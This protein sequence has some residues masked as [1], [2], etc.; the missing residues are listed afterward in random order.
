MSV[1]FSMDSQHFPHGLIPNYHF[2]MRISMQWWAGGLRA[3]WKAARDEHNKLT[4]G[5]KVTEHLD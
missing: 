1:L 2:S 4:E 5:N 3:W